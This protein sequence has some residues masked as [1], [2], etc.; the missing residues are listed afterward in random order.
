MSESVCQSRCG[1]LWSLEIPLK[2]LPKGTN[3]LFV[4]GERD[5]MCSIS[6]L[7]ATI[8][9]MACRSTT[10]LHVCKGGKHNPFDGASASEVE[11]I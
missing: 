3:V 7:Q 8:S 4:L 1:R 9:K 5:R 2:Q 11:K 10:A 6:K